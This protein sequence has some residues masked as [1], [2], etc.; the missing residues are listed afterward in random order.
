MLTIA[1]SINYLYAWTAPSAN[2][3]NNNVT[4]PLN[5]SAVAQTKSG[6]LG[7]GAFSAFGSAYIQGNL[8]V[9][10]VSPQYQ[11]DLNGGS[12]V[13]AGIRYPDGSIQT[14]AG[15]GASCVVGGVT[16]AH[17]VVYSSACSS[18]VRTFYQCWDGTAYSVGNAACSGTGGGGGRGT[19]FTA[20]TRVSMADGSFKEL[21]KVVVGD[22]VVGAGGKINTVLSLDRTL[23]WKGKN[24]H[25]IRINGEK[26]F[27]TD[28]HPVM[29]TNGW[30]AVNPAVAVTEAYDQLK[31]KVGTLKVGDDIVSAGGKIV[32][33]NSIDIVPQGDES[34]RLYNLYVDG[35][36]TYYAND[37]LVH[38]GVPDAAGLYPLENMHNGEPEDAPSL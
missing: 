35:D 24:Q 3:P 23:L 29:T 26:E 5:T 15:G 28:N 18:S 32:H 6:A 20:S 36:H 19:C 8:G 14:T 7:T 38:G 25:L 10:V 37:L 11:I 17:G 4:S 1:L 12:G 34:V 33:V 21:H 31:G 9:G 30:E 2:P 13:S 27:M 22:R 16:R